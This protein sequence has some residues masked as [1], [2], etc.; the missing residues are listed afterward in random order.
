MTPA[1]IADA[2]DLGIEETNSPSFGHSPV[3]ASNRPQTR[4]PPIALLK[5]MPETDELAR[6]AAPGV[7]QTTDKGILNFQLS[8]ME[9]TP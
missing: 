5:P 9:R 3:N 2:M 4:I 7:D 6:R 8:K 1:S